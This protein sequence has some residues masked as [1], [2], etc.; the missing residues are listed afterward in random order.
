M[1]KQ[2]LKEYQETIKNYY[3][4]DEFNYHF[5]SSAINVV[6][7]QFKNRIYNIIQFDTATPVSYD[8]EVIE[9][10]NDIIKRNK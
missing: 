5:V 6:N 9:N 1:Q 8:V 4:E 7:A 2:L 3:G 10:R